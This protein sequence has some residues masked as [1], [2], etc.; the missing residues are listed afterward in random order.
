MFKTILHHYLKGFTSSFNIIPL[1]LA[2][3]SNP[4]LTTYIWQIFKFNL[5]FIV[6][7]HLLCQFIGWFGFNVS[8]LSWLYY[9]S[10]G[11]ISGIF[12]ATHYLDITQIISQD[13][14]KTDSK[15]SF[16][17][18]ISI[19]ITM[20]I[21]QFAIYLST[22]VIYYLLVDKFYVLMIIIKYIVI[23]IYHALYCYNNV[24][25]TMNI[26]IGKRID[27][28][29]K[30]WPYY[31][32][33][34]SLISFIYYY[35]QNPII[36][37]VYNLLLIMMLSNP[38]LIKIHFPSQRK[39]FAINLRIFTYVMNCIVGLSTGTIQLIRYAF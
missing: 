17:D 3:L 8:L 4:K 26:D 7:P 25:H 9:C 35:I 22:N 30:R 23:L 20:M 2:S 15:I 34:A 21:Y 18:K 39:Y 33:Y 24:W 1:Y 11:I 16:I 5:I 13:I 27:I 6:L 38:F 10:V 36:G 19:A 37:A 28:L 31:F 12:H 29:E 14:Q 32:G